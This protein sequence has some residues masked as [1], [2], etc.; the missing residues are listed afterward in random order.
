M[1]TYMNPLC[2]LSQYNR[3]HVIDNRNSLLHVIE[4][5]SSLFVLPLIVYFLLESI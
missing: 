4:M 2:E 5:E 1:L 3:V